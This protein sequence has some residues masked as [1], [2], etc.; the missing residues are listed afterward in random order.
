MMFG[1]WVTFF[2]VCIIPNP[3]FGKRLVPT[4]DVNCSIRKVFVTLN[5]YRYHKFRGKGNL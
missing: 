2:F 1:F 5:P 3:I 4:G